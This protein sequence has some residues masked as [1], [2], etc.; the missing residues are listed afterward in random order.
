MMTWYTGD[1]TFDTV[2]TIGFAF[3]GLTILG[4]ILSPQTPYGRFGNDNWGMTL[5][6]KFGWWLMEIPA[7]VVFLW[8]FINGD[9][10][11]QLVPLILAAV[12]CIHYGN[13]GWFFPLS[14]RVA[15]NRKSTFSITIVLSGMFVTAIHGYLNA[16]WFS[17]FGGHL[18]REWLS[19]PRFWIGLVVYYSGFALI[20]HS[21]W[22]V[23]NLRDPKKIAAG[24]EQDYKIPY[25]GGFRFVSSPTYLG[26]L[27]AWT[28]FAIMTWG[29]PGVVILLIS[30]GNLIPRAIATK[31]WYA[32]KFPDYP[33]D[34]K[35]IFPY[36]L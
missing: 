14:I 7:T 19:D 1:P 25:G 15:P 28:G 33:T 29:L 2:L 18:T 3:A 30:A 17:K 36:V 21:E 5:N 34:R 22:V 35:A 23:R 4:G 11:T 12:W 9:H 13:R 27:M 6:P 16:T 10:P 24:K 26:E 32:E 8:F 31:R 20:L